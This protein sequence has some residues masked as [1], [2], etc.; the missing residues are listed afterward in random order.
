MNSER[1]VSEVVNF[2]Y[3]ER[4]IFGNLGGLQGSYKAEPGTE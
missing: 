4:A 2:S 1:I 3:H